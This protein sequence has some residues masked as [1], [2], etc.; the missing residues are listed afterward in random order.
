MLSNRTALQNKLTVMKVIMFSFYLIVVRGLGLICGHFGGCN[1]Q[2]C[3]LALRYSERCFQYYTQLTKLQFTKVS[4]AD[5]LAHTKIWPHHENPRGAGGARWSGRVSA[6]T[7]L[8]NFSGP[9]GP[10]AI[11][12]SLLIHGESSTGQWEPGVMYKKASWAG[13]TTATA[14]VTGSACMA[15]SLSWDTTWYS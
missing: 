12:V 2:Y 11:F 3:W 4:T 8:G 15:Q 7:S 9:C 1:L 13:P 14:L 10:L 6:A 5:L